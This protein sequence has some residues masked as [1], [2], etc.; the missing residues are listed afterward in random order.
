MKKYIVSLTAVVFAI[1]M[2]SWTSAHKT[3]NQNPSGDVFWVLKSGTIAT[4]DPADY[5]PGSDDCQQDVHFCGFYAPENSI[6]HEPDI[7]A[8]SALRAD[9]ANLNMDNETPYNSS[10][11]ISFRD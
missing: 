1:A 5:Q 2:A 11:K 10:Q 7:P 8:G 6:T 4:T 3:V 9:L